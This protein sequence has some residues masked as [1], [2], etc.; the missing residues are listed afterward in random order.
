MA[1]YRAPCPVCGC[2]KTKCVLVKDTIDL[3]FD[4]IRRR[5][6]TECGHRWWTAQKFETVVKSVVWAERGQLV[7]EVRE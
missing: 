7:L 2:T 1:N 5:K 3:R 6:C 4:T